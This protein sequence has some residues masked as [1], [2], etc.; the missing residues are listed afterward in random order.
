[1]SQTWTQYQIA[2][3]RELR[4]MSRAIDRVAF[5]PNSRMRRRALRYL[6]SLTTRDEFEYL[7][8]FLSIKSR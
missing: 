2:H 5:A 6:R 4:K 3:E 7:E 8:S 1:M